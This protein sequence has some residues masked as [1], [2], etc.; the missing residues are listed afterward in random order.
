MKVVNFELR[1]MLRDRA[2]VLLALVLALAVALGALNGMRWLHFQQR[3]L[4][5]LQQEETEKLATAR[6][7]AAAILSG[8]Q[9]APRGWWS[10][11]ADVRG[12]AYGFI[13]TYA[14]KPADVLSALTAGQTDLLPY[15]FKVTAGQRSA[16]LSAYETENPR[17]LLLGRFDLAFVVIFLLPLV[18]LALSYNALA[19]E[20]EEGRLGLLVTHGVTP[21]ALTLIRVSVRSVVLL[22]I[23]AA[24][25][26][27]AL[28]ITGFDFSAR[29][30]SGSLAAWFTIALAYAAFWI[31]ITLLTIAL[32]RTAATTAL[33]LAGA[34]LVLVVIAPWALN[35]IANQLHPLPS[36]TEYILAQRTA[37]DAAEAKSSALLGRYLQDHPELAP[38]NTPID[39]M[40][41]SAA[42]IATTEHIEAQLRPVQA[43]FD[44]QLARQQQL[45][46]RW[47]WLSPAVL[48]QQTLNEIAGAGW[49]RHR[50]FLAQADA[51]IDALRAYFNPRVLSG[52]FEFAA[53][54]EWP[55]YVW[56]EPAPIEAARRFRSAIVGLLLAAVAL[57]AIAVR[58]LGPRQ[59]IA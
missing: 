58:L 49:S 17:R 34:W 22:T 32:V 33:M 40:D 52:R 47:Q 21:R 37:T 43:A 13:T 38:K 25:V 45:I 51:Y 18:L 24:A 14:V 10:N 56:R 59:A 3:A 8:E 12:F 28:V 1:A 44:A 19:I 27:A 20:R 35:L 31:A 41:Y 15:Y 7:E 9:A 11:P 57:I 46:D 30:G 50:A 26:I 2:F 42:S 39:A 53:F 4:T 16:A 23:G 36:R 29:S 54:D 6:A 48:A 5:V 55:R